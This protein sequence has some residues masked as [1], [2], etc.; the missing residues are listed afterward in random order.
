VSD[1]LKGINSAYAY[2]DLLASELL[3][4]SA[5]TL[6]DPALLIGLC[7]LVVPLAGGGGL[8]IRGLGHLHRYMSL[9]GRCPSLA[10]CCH[11]HQPTYNDRA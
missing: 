2:L 5:E 9:P 8:A 4:S 6:G 3:Y 7:L 10:E 1:A 11:S